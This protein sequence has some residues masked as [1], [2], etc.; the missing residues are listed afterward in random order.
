MYISRSEQFKQLFPDEHSFRWKQIE[1]ALFSHPEK[2]WE[3]CTMLSKIMREKI[4]SIPWISLQQFALVS[5]KVGDVYKSV[6]RTEDDF[7]LESV[8]MR[9]ARGHWTICLSS[10]IGCAMNCSFCATGKM[11]FMRN[12]SCEE[13]EDQY[14]FWKAFLQNNQNVLGSITN[15]VVMG[16]GEP[17]AN[18]ENVR[19]ALSHILKYTDIGQSHITVSSVGI[20]PQLEKL[21]DD[22]LWPPVRMA[23]SLHSAD[24]KTRK[25]IV[26]TSYDEFLSRISKWAIRYLKKHN[27][28]R[29]HIT[30]EHIMLSGKNDSMLH[31][32]ALVQ[33]VHVIGADLVRINLIPYNETNRNNYRRSESENIL[34]FY[35]YLRKHGVSVTIRKNMGTDIAAACGQLISEVEK[36]A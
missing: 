9:N 7:L 34:L 32:K 6:L 12:L 1:R 22:P 13:I 18:Y 24:P 4:V 17:M 26:P 11:G 23:I 19:D 28:K 30:F 27:A 2:S 31:A 21:I 14:R 29:N 3:G 5:N 33:F 15:I 25:S 10:Q 8:F 16:M 20:I 36:R 35:G